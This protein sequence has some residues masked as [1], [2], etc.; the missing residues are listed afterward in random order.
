[1]S[2]DSFRYDVFISYSRIDSHIVERV[3]AAF[4]KV[5]I[6]YFI[7]RQGIGGGLEF[8]EVLAYAILESR[9]FLF[10]ASKNS[11]DSKFTNSEITF[12]FNKKD[13]NSII[14][15]IIDGSTMPIRL[16][17]VFSAIN[18]RNITEHP[19]ES[20][21][22]NDILKL[23]GKTVSKSTEPELTLPKPTLPKP[24]APKPTKP[25]PTVPE[26]TAEEKERNRLLSIPDKDIIQYKENGKYG[27]KVKSTG[28]I[29]IAAKYGAYFH[30]HFCEGLAAVELNGKW[31]YIDKS[32][33]EIIPLKYS[34]AAP[35]SEGLATVRLNGKWGY[36]DKTGKE[37]IPLKYDE[38]RS[39]SEGLAAV[40][41]NGKWGYIDKTGKEVVS[42]KYDELY[43]HIFHEGLTDVK[44]NGKWG[45]I[46]KTGK[47]IIPMRYDKAHIFSEGLAAVKLNNKWGYID[48]TGKEVIPIKYNQVNEFFNGLARVE[49]KG[50][51][52]KDNYWVYIDK[53]GNRVK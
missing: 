2:S 8:P 52:F 30:Y 51:W 18:W 53:N 5:G 47:E 1:M 41:L 28:E 25:E 26:Q 50:N 44:L 29:I 17:F 22:V 4:D 13:K 7:D 9:I 12:A 42:L 19:V 20:V 35:F 32:G 23:L 16:E 43:S 36:I 21:L 48:K 14:P 6:T 38:A 49:I 24:T 10:L 39:F 34:F 37:V 15:Y 33:K 3:C 40:R 46:D 11:Y 31:G 27:F 45:Y